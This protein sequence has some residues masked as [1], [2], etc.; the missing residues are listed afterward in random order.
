MRTLEQLQQQ[1]IALQAEVHSAHSN[2]VDA[3]TAAATTITQN[4]HFSLPAV[5]TTAPIPTT[6]PIPAATP[7]P[8]PSMHQLKGTDLERFNGNQ[9]WTKEFLYVIKLVIVI[10]PAAFP[11]N[12]F[13]ILYALS[14]M[15][16]GSVEIWA[17]NG[18]S[19]SCCS[20]PPEII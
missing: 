19:N 16:K 11:D 20:T 14:F 1:N 9:S 5:P 10:S 15:T 13:K 17:H 2:I 8:N 3:T 4:I 7:V 18:V 6:T 12:R